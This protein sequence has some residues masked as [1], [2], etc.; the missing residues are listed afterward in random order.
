[1]VYPSNYVC[2]A[3]TQIAMPSAARRVCLGA[4]AAD[5][6]FGEARR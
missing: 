1:M 4:L 5:E 6:A 3:A 2:E